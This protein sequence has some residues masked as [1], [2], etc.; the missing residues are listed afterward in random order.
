[1]QG[2]YFYQRLGI[3]IISI[4][5]AN[6]VSQECLSHGAHMDRTYLARIEQGRVNPSLRVLHK[7]AKALRVPLSFLFDGV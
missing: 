2:D 4:R 3:R 1:M 5:K 6:K 7:I